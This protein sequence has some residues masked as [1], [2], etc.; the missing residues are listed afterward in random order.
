LGREANGVLITLLPVTHIVQALPSETLGRQA[1]MATPRPK[2]TQIL[3]DVAVEYHCQPMLRSGQ[4][5]MCE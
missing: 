2:P 1:H 4:A 5:V 3:H